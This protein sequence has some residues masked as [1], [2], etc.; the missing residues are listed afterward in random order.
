VDLNEQ[1]SI[2]NYEEHAKEEPILKLVET[3]QTK[4]GKEMISRGNIQSRKPTYE[5]TT[6]FSKD[7]LDDHKDR[8]KK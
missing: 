1:L 4:F 6:S 5:S 8:E 2:Y 3:L 7:F